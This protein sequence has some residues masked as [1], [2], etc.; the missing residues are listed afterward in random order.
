[1]QVTVTLRALFP[2]IP[3]PPLLPLPHLPPSPSHTLTPLLPQATPPHSSS[4]PPTPTSS[5]SPLLKEG[6][7]PIIRPNH[8]SVRPMLSHTLLHLP[9]ALQAPP[10]AP[11]PA[12]RRQLSCSAARALVAAIPSL[13]PFPRLSSGRIPVLANTLSHP[14]TIP[15]LTPP[16]I[17]TVTRSTRHTLV[18]LALTPEL[19]PATAMLVVVLQR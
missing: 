10:P 12:G 3:P 8:L 2:P 11:P 15:T 19:V 7:D 14:H 9:A 16:T 4:P 13:V 18:V 1:M 5:P 6:E 17:T